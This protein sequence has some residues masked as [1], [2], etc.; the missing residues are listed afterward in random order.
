MENS[1]FFITFIL[2]SLSF[3]AAIILNLFQKALFNANPFQIKELLESKS[4]YRLIDRFIQEDKIDKFYF[5]VDTTKNLSLIFSAGLVFF[6]HQIPFI[7]LG[8]AIFILIDIFSSFLVG[9]KCE[10]VLYSTSTLSIFFSYL[11]F[12]LTFLILLTKK[13]LTRPFSTLT[14]EKEKLWQMI[15]LSS[16][17]PMLNTQEQKIIASFLTFKEKSVREIMIPRVNLFSLNA[18]TTIKEA[19]SYFLTEDYSRIPV[20]NKTLDN[21]IGV[22]HYKDILKYFAEYKDNLL[23]EPIEKLIKPILYAPENKM[24][25]ELFQEFKSR[26][27]HMAIIVN[28]YGGTEGIVTIEDILEELVG[29]IKDEHDINEN[30]QFCHLPNGSVIVD[31]KMSIL[32]LENVLNIKIPTSPEYETIGGF[33]FQKAGT[34]V[35]KGWNIQLDD[36]ELEVLISND[37]CIE[38]IKITPIAKE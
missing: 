21:I 32:D 9:K 2:S 14:M 31:A 34:I 26:H 15:R 22:L 3:T 35:A 30:K 36:F 18:K 10:T 25:S 16:L 38:K 37:R 6:N 12:P 29:E 27:M 5:L 13:S 1:Y 33:I 7:L 19:I 24:I 28:E 20:F 4:F 11:F 17:G 8:I 23:N